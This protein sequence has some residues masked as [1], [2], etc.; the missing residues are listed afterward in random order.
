MESLR[1]E[2]SNIKLL[3]SGTSSL[4]KE[5]EEHKKTIQSLQTE[6]DKLREDNKHLVEATGVMEQVVNQYKD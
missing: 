1:S 6:N 5:V 2:I 4:Q 3:L